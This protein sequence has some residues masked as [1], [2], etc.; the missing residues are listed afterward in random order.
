[1]K[2][3]QLT[4]YQKSRMTKC[5]YCGKPI[6]ENQEF[7]YCSTKVGRYTAYAF[8]HNDC[9]ALAQAFVRGVSHADMASYSTQDEV[10]HI[11]RASTYSKIYQKEEVLK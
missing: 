8:I 1:M 9:I 10:E 11:D 3:S 5:I 7:Q 2:L 6:T 4:K